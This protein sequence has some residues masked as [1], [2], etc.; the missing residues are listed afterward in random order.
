MKS[1]VIAIISKLKFYNSPD[2]K[3]LLGRWALDNCNKARN[4]KIDLSNEDHCGV[5]NQYRHKV[6]RIKK[7]LY[8]NKIIDIET[9]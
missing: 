2:H 3:V 7:E 5:C 4:I 6:I 8:H 9:V 1:T